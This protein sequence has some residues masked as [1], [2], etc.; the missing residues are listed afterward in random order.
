MPIQVNSSGWRVKRGGTARG[1][2]AADPALPGLPSEFLT[3]RS[4]VADEVVV[5]P[6]PVTRGREATAPT[7]DI[8]YDLSPGQTAVL[9]VRHPSGALTFHL[10]VESTT[11]GVRGPSE[12]RF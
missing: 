10:P 9:A 5:E 4:E 12:V 1:A 2:A 11:R 8:S 7:L 6:A 3:D